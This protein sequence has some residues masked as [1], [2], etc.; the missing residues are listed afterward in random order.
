MNMN[1]HVSQSGDAVLNALNLYFSKNP[2]GN[3]LLAHFKI[4]SGKVQFGKQL[5]SNEFSY[6]IFVV[7][8]GTYSET[9]HFFKITCSAKVTFVF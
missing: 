1:V 7:F 3:F 9:S 6:A 4:F 8:V 5:Q 2:E